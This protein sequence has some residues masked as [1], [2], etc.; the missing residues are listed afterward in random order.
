MGYDALFFDGSEDSDLI[1]TA[2]KED[3]VILTRDTHIMEWGVVARGRVKAVLIRNDQSERQVRQVVSEL[4]LETVIKPF[5]I[6]LGCNQPLHTVEKADI[7]QR[8]PPYVFETQDQFVECPKCH[9][10]YWR[11]THWRNMLKKLESLTEVD[12]S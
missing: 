7:E 11:G 1:S 3:R 12:H 5:T 6:C 4:K 9:R 10:V 8:V 2:L